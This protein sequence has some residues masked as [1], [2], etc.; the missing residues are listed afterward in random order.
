MAS[1]FEKRIRCTRCLPR[2]LRK[3]FMAAAGAGVVP[4]LA[5]QRRK[6]WAH[7]RT[8]G[9]LANAELRRVQLLLGKKPGQQIWDTP[10]AGTTRRWRSPKRRRAIASRQHWRR[11]SPRCRK[12]FTTFIAAGG[13]RHQAHAG[14]PAEQGG[15]VAVTIRQDFKNHSHQRKLAEPTD[16]TSEVRGGKAAAG[17]AVE[18]A[19]SPSQ[20]RPS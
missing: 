1:D 20:R 18:T 12:P 14:R 2:I 3:S 4:R 15:C 16:I 6:S 7:I 17:G 19:G 9:D 11:M 10:M 13:W 5:A 8:I